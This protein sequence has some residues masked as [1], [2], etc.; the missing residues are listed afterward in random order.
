METSLFSRSVLVALGLYLSLCLARGSGRTE[1]LAAQSDAR[2][3]APAASQAQR[4]ALK[5]A[6]RS[7]QRF[8]A[9]CHGD[10]HTGRDTRADL[11][12]IPDLSKKSWHATRTDAQLLVSILKGKGK[13]MPAFGDR[14]TTAQARDLVA[15]LRKV[16]GA[17]AA[18]PASARAYAQRFEELV[19]MLQA[20]QDEFWR[21]A[22]SPAKPAEKTSS[23]PLH[24]PN[25]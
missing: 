6:Q 3:K 1:P 8:C 9:R 19:K 25:E 2:G 18:A 21:L 17:K 12:T 20:L 4:A 13:H 11:P 24:P 7:Y 23:T 15:Y 14:L 10:D 16:G 22:S 5:A